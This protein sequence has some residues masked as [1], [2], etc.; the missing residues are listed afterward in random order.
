MRKPSKPFTLGCLTG[1]FTT[2]IVLV[3]TITITLY[4]ILPKP[5]KAPAFTVGLKADYNWHVTS[6][7][8]EIFEMTQAKGKPLFLHFWR[9]SCFV[10]VTELPGINALY[11]LIKDD[12]ITFISISLDK[13][14]ED[15]DGLLA[16][17]G[18]HF[19]VYRIDKSPPAVFEISKTPTVYVV[20]PNGD[21]VL[22]HSGSA[23]WE[24]ASVIKMLRSL[25][26]SD[27]TESDGEERRA[28]NQI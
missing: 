20:A 22:K 6:L 26:P 8:G 1:A 11:D 2:I 14:I 9:P 12:N 15:A 17:A 28:P 19:P 10:C 27:A 25:K 24:D 23:N 4:I 13:D 21:I 16:S 5:P 7:D 3:V 18:T